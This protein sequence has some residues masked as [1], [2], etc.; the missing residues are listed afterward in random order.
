MGTLESPELLDITIL[1][2]NNTFDDRLRTAW[3]FSALVRYGET[4]I[5]FDTGGDAPTLMSNIDILQ[6]DP[7]G[8]DVIVLSHIHNDHV[9]GLDGFLEQASQPTIYLPP[10]FPSA[11]KQRISQRTQ[12]VEVDPGQEIVGGA[13]STGEMGSSILEQ[14]LAIHTR[15]GLVVITG[16]AH[17]G[18]VE[19]VEKAKEITGEQV[20]LVLGG[21]HL[22]NTPNSEIETIIENFRKL[23][24]KKVAPTH[25]TGDPAIAK[26]EDEYGED[27]IRAGVGLEIHIR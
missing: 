21:F 22:G 3:G 1:Y 11:F 23:G 26:F 24:V 20:H 27:F 5:L 4:T 8:V 14:A 9:G 16:C 13:V 12:I 17:P 10:S 7:A 6:V 25:C 18:I 15:E 19:I 2:D